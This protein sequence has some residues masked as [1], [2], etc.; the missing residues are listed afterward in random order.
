M[1]QEANPKLCT[2]AC[3]KLRCLLR[4]LNLLEVLSK[5]LEVEAHRHP[6][7]EISVPHL[8]EV[9]DGSLQSVTWR[10]IYEAKG[11]W[12]HRAPGKRLD[13]PWARKVQ[14]AKPFS[15]RL[16]VQRLSGGEMQQ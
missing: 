16:K 2:E 12:I 13:L 15:R 4:V 7:Q 10:R 8:L 5:I 9:D 14:V 3:P 6:G 11:T 1:T